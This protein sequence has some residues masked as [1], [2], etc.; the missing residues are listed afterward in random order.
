M[1]GPN[2]PG[3]FAG[4]WDRTR[5]SYC[6]SEPAL[7]ERTVAEVARERAVDPV[8]LLFDLGLASLLAA[9]FRMAVVNFDEDEVAEL[10]LDP[11]TVLGLSDAGA[12]ASQLCDAC[13]STHLLARWVRERG[14]L[15][16]ERAV[17]MLTGR[18]ADVLGLADRGRLAVGWPA[19]VVVFDPEAVAPSPLRRVH[20]LP[21]G[22]ERLVA[23]AVGIDAVIV[24]GRPIRRGGKDLVDPDGPLPGRLLRNGR[25]RG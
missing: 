3:P 8:D 23:D 15:S 5:I 22:A 21:A 25:A 12:H 18:P 17:H 10:L 16:L 20:D 7:E 19:D 13:F 24:N 4:A 11:A 2:A 6:P 1:L 14:V 9:R